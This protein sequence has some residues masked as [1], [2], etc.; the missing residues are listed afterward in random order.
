MGKYEE[1][2]GELTK[3]LYTRSK[4]EDSTQHQQ[5][6][7]MGYMPLELNALFHGNRIMRIADAEKIADY[8]GY[9]IELVRK[10]D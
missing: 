5:A 2:N 4:L 9:R 1:L 10:E 3:K 8:L 6:V 7:D